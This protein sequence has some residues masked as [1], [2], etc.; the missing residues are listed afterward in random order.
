MGTGMG[1][2]DSIPK[3]Q[4]LEVDEINPFPTRQQEGNEKNDSPTISHDFPILFLIPFVNW[5][6]RLQEWNK[7]NPFQ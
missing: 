2:Y 6:I 3:V 1:M 7:M 5:Q 4:D